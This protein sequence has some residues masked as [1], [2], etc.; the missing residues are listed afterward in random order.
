MAQTKLNNKQKAKVENWQ[1]TLGTRSRIVKLVDRTCGY[2]DVYLSW[3]K[4]LNQ[5]NNQIAIVNYL[6]RLELTKGGGLRIEETEQEKVNYVE[7]CIEGE[8]IPLFPEL[9]KIR[10]RKVD[11]SLYP[12]DER[13][14]TRIKPIKDRQFSLPLSETEQKL[15]D[16]SIESGDLTI[17]SREELLSGKEGWYSL[18][19][20]RA[21]FLPAPI[22]TLLKGF[23]CS[24]SE[25]E[26]IAMLAGVISPQALLFWVEQIPMMRQ[27]REFEKFT[28]PVAFKEAKKSVQHSLNKRLPKA[29]REA[30]SQKQPFGI[31]Y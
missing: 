19:Q 2:R 18:D 11:Q 22:L 30:Q 27:T 17:Y 8:I 14:Q 28:E 24:L 5:P 4:Q 3:Q 15:L 29:V 13:Q 1:F 31:N 6:S 26:A 12:R 21:V 25:C 7:G 9:P 10:A 23:N 20:N 16:I